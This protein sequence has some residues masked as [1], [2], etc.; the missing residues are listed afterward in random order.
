MEERAK[1]ILS[2]VGFYGTLA[3]CLTVIGV[4]GWMLLREEPQTNSDLPIT[5]QTPVS[6]TVEMPE[7]AVETADT[8]EIPVVT[9]IPEPTPVIAETEELPPVEVDDTPVA[10]AAPRL[11]VE[12]LRG[13]VLTAFSMEELVY[14]QTLGDWRT[15]DGVDI[16][17]QA[18][19]AVLAACAGTVTDVTEDPLLGT[20]VCL[21]H[22][23]G[24]RTTYANL[25][26][27][28]NVETGD[29]VSAG[30]IIGAVGST[31]A[32]EGGAPHLHFAVTRDG[33]AVDPD[34][35]LNR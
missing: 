33:K 15:H 17:A 34:E 32:A 14:S 1:K 12:P 8:A 5:P 20:M 9:E 25:Q 19:A 11:T 35:F 6:E 28:P 22:D 31:A 18:G 3:A 2:G 29:T 27:R 30:Q 4:C 7:R 21:E 26:T 23:G 10:A 24:Y 13:N 16:A